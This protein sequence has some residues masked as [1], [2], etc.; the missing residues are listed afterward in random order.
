MKRFILSC[1]VLIIASLNNGILAD[2]IPENIDTTNFNGKPKKKFTI[3]VFT[4]FFGEGLQLLAPYRSKYHIYKA[5]FDP[6]S[7]EIVWHLSKKKSFGNEGW[8][9]LL[10]KSWWF[11]SRYCLSLF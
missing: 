2:S 9:E 5:M 6:L 7:I 1:F 3:S 11:F 4:G 10:P 8:I